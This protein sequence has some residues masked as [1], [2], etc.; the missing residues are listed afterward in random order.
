MGK[1]L[2]H[3]IADPLLRRIG[4]GAAAYLV[5]IGVAT[6]TASL[7]EAGLIAALGVSIDLVSSYLSRRNR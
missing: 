5:G 4:T 1:S 2:F 7:I 3:N 6:E